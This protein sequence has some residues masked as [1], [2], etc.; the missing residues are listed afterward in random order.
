MGRNQGVRRDAVRD[1]RGSDT[2]SG[3]ATCRSGRRHAARRHRRPR[4]SPRRP[5]DVSR[6]APSS[7]PG[8]RWHHDRPDRS[9]SRGRRDLGQHRHVRDPPAKAQSCR[10]Q[11]GRHGG[12]PTAIQRRSA[13]RDDHESHEHASESAGNAPSVTIDAGVTAS[14]YTEDHQSAS[15][16]VRPLSQGRSRLLAVYIGGRDADRRIGGPARGTTRRGS[17]ILRICR[18]ICEPA[19][20]IRRS[21]CSARSRRRARNSGLTLAMVGPASKWEPRATLPGAVGLESD[22]GGLSYGTRTR[23]AGIPSTRSRPGGFPRRC[24]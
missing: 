16:L 4:V 1:G 2:G 21:W 20:E 14:I 23:T 11:R 3:P 19:V 17:W 24:R 9:R 15:V 6:R 12:E 18:L 5:P 22:S 10:A 8:S 13:L 7:R